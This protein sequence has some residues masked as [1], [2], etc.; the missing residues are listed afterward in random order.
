MSNEHSELERRSR[1]LFH[2]SVAELDGPTR[3]R[4][5]AARHTALAE[6]AP[7]R[8]RWLGAPALA[9][10]A[11][12]AAAALVAV[13]WLQRPPADG[14]AVVQMASAMDD[15]DLLLEYEVVQDLEFYD[16]LE[17]QPELRDAGGPG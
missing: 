11:S 4:L 13:A 15:L 1:E 2:A 9:A 8:P 12:I 16:W 17:Q 5:A 3:A 10:A 14:E 7:P 6:L